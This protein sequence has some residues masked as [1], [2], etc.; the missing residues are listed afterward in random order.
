MTYGEILAKYKHSDAEWTEPEE[1]IPIRFVPYKSQLDF[2]NSVKITLK[3]DPARDDSKTRQVRFPKFSGGSL[4]DFLQ[5]EKHI[6]DVIANKPCTTPESMFTNSQALLDGEA[7]ANWLTEK[8]RHEKQVMTDPKDQNKTIPVPCD[9]HLYEKVRKAFKKWYVKPEMAEKEKR[10]LRYNIKSV[11]GLSVQQNLGRFLEINRELGLFEIG[12]DATPLSDYEQ[13]V[14]FTNMQSR[15]RRCKFLESGKHIDNMTLQQIA[16]YYEQLE[17]LEGLEKAG[18]VRKTGKGYDA[19]ADDASRNDANKRQRLKTSKTGRKRKSSDKYCHSCAK[20]NF[21]YS[22]V[23]SHNDADC[24]N[25]GKRF[26]KDSHKKR[27]G[28]KGKNP[29]DSMMKIMEDVKK[30]IDF[31]TI[32]SKT[33]ENSSESEV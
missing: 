14:I 26:R 23:H 15:R 28:E 29:S 19:S 18:R 31:L 10:Y 24:R 11:Y 6:R 12:N 9:K 20:N 33:E 13:K 30:G 21:G 1:K 22:V 4:E 17:T 5:N 32:R 3:D 2:T 7:L 27:D 16:E 25:K 8:D